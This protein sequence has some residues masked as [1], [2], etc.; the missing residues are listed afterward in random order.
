MTEPSSMSTPGSRRLAAVVFADVVDFT[1]L[2]AEDEA[3]ALEVIEA[4]RTAAATAATA[5]GGEVV[6][7]L[8]D[9]ALLEFPSL[10]G[11]ADGAVALHAAFRS[12]QEARGRSAPC[13]LR[14]GLHFGDVAVGPDGDI[15]GDGVNRASRLQGAAEPGSTVVSEDVARQ[16]RRRR[17]LQLEDLGPRG[18]KGLDEPL[19]IFTLEPEASLR[20]R[21]GAA[22]R[23]AGGGRPERVGRLPLSRRHPRAMAVGI[24]AG[25]VT[26]VG[27]GVWTALTPAE[28]PRT[29][30]ILDGGVDPAAVAVLP[31]DNLSPDPGDAYIAAGLTDELGIAL[32]RVEGLRVASRR[33]AEEYLRQGLDLPTLAGRLGVAR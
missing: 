4:L 32:A 28:E 29:E 12:A 23:G 9:G 25:L 33:S 11:A 2:S 19:R 18:F 22:L 16:L 3:G 27:L 6:K 30:P 14:I 15:Y 10:D 5:F 13:A 24:A 7:Y 1:R 21:T 17:D 20:E 8:G 31:F 26:F